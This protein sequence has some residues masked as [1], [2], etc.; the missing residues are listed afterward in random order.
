MKCIKFIVGFLLISFI[1]ISLIACSS[2]DNN[3]PT[4]VNYVGTQSPG[5]YWSWTE[6]TY[7]GAGT[8]TAVNNSKSPSYSYS[9]SV[10]PLTGISAGFSKLNITSSSDTNI[11]LPAS[12]Y[13][14]EIP[15]TMV[16]AAVAPFYTFNQSGT[17]QLS[18]HGPVVAAAQGSCPSDGTTTVNWVVM[19]DENWCPAAGA[20]ISTGT[21]SS[22]DNAYGT[23]VITV[24]SGTY[25][26]SVTPY[27]LDGT[28]GEAVSLSS[29]TCS[30]GVIQCTDSK[31]KTVHI[32]FTPSG[33]FI[34]D[35]EKHGITGVVQPASNI[36]ISNFLTSGN[37]F[38]GMVF[39]SWEDYYDGCTSDTDCSGSHN[40]VSGGKCL[41]ND[42]HGYGYCGVPETKPV[43][44]TA[45]G[46]N[47]N[48]QTY[49]DI[50][51]GTLNTEVTAV[52]LSGASQPS[53]GLL[54]TSIT[55]PSTGCN[56][57]GTF[58]MVMVVTQINNKYV[59][60]GL[61]HSTCP[62]FD[63]PFNVLTIQQ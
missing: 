62:T 61:T 48:A 16:M 60:F 30:S 63:T 15:N 11:T 36:N 19:P 8:F 56:I 47:L 40:G 26:I 46:T 53:P 34:M 31:S 3:T 22:A 21:C 13:E 54:K 49:S 18:I 4:T 44:V 28:A 35:T 33:I 10:S 42:G 29:C 45:D 55:Y 57:P 9:G 52:N 23:A 24:S 17:V 38:K 51:N 14:I 2:N 37:S 1:A 50:D 59:A 5:D 41:G 25:A 39:D 6:T 58:P 27:H 12:A 20:N 43:S 7:N 32:A